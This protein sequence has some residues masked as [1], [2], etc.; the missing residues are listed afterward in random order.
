MSFLL[1]R[2][3]EETGSV[4]GEVFQGDFSEV[5]GAFRRGFPSCFYRKNLGRGG[6]KGGEDVG[7]GEEKLK[8]AYRKNEFCDHNQQIA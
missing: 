6:E 7:E 1:F 3:G 5:S 8:S 2:G 4:F